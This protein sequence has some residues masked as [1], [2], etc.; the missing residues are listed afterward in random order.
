MT[1]TISQPLGT[2]LSSTESAVR[3][4]VIASAALNFP[5]TL[6][7]DSLSPVKSAEKTSK[8]ISKEALSLSKT[9]T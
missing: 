7:H 8:E 9:L 5:T 4:E 2:F 3:G 6:L 1:N